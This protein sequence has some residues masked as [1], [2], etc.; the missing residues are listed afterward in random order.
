M[1]VAFAIIATFVAAFVIALVV[2]T[3]PTVVGRPCCETFF[4]PRAIFL[5]ELLMYSSFGSPRSFKRYS[6]TPL[7][8]IDYDFC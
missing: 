4:Y 6:D 1:H 2:A 5:P 7:K 8:F 3:L